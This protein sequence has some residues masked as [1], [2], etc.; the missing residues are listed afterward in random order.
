[1]AYTPQEKQD[2]VDRFCS[3]MESGK[4]ARQA[5]KEEGM[6]QS[7]TFYK[8]LSEEKSFSE[9]YARACEARADA[10]FE[11]ILNIADDNG[12][13]TRTTADGVE[14]V[15]NDVIQRSR[16]R[17]DARKWMLSKM[18]PKKYGDKLDITSDNE[19]L[20]LTPEER[21]A[22]IALYKAKLNAK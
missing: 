14:L 6:P 19:S 21:A 7:S 10:I 11:D 3:L 12:N 5:L 2:I 20:N 8:W 17:V 16:L 22:K 18:M 15:N 4:S 13:D 9:Q 1:M